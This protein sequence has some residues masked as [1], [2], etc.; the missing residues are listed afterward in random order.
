MGSIE[1]TVQKLLRQS[2][3][4][5][6]ILFILAFLVRQYVALSYWVSDSRIEPAVHMGDLVLGYRLPFLFNPEKAIK[7]GQIVAHRCPAD[8]SLC[9]GRIL[10]VEGDRVQVAA[11]GQITVNSQ[12]TSWTLAGE[13][14]KA[15]KPADLVVT[16]GHFYSSAWGLVP[17]DKIESQIVFLWF[18]TQKKA[19]L[20]SVR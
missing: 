13:A 9:L 16:P 2:F 12:L 17:S 5:L 19:F 14:A 10:A 11:D 20:H 1:Q 6:V 8:Q 7:K 3:E 15:E 4:T 18:S